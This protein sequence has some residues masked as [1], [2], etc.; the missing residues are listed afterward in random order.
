M[1]NE[2]VRELALTVVAVGGAG[3]VL[4]GASVALYR[5]AR[6]LEELRRH[7]RM[8]NG[9]HLG[10]VVEQIKTR[11]ERGDSRFEGIAGWIDEHEQRHAKGG[12]R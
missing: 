2:T 10:E 3:G 6:F 12:Q 7:V 9:Q 8:S 1:T 11:L 5:L 4:A